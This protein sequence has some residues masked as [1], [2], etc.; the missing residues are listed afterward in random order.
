MTQATYSSMP[1]ECSCILKYY[2][3]N[4]SKCFRQEVAQ[5]VSRRRIRG[6]EKRKGCKKGKEGRL[7]A[8]T[9]FFN[10]RKSK[11][12]NAKEPDKLESASLQL[13]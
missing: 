6:R 12:F 10:S 11:P 5:V 2:T 3:V 9:L 4:I 13:L 8:M 1:G 7:A